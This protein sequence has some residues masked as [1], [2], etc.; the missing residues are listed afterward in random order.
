[1]SMTGGVVF[2]PDL[3]E[4][5]AHSGI[6]VVTTLRHFAIVTYPVE[7]DALK[8]HLHP[9]F[10]PDCVETASGRTVGLV[11]V[12]PFFDVDFCA[13]TFPSPR[14]SFGQTNYR[15]YIH[16]TESGSRAVWF[17]G[18]CLG[19]WTVIVPRY[20]WQLPWHHG[21][22][23]FNCDY[24]VE[25]QRYVRYEMKTDSAWAPASLELEDTGNPVAYFDGFSDLE[26]GLV[27]LTHPLQGFYFRRDGYLGSY[28]IWHD[29][30]Q[31]TEGR[32]VRASFPLL[33]RLGLVRL[34]DQSNPHSVVLQFET[35]FAIY[36]PPKRM[37]HASKL[38]AQGRA[39]QKAA[40]DTGQEAFRRGL[41][42]S[43][44]GPCW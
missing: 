27:V 30:I 11:S 38:H 29:R 37:P 9:R 14:L 32:L 36:L 16:D 10:V 40:P 7:P 19:S 34:E 41:E 17:F 43:R 15:A 2:T 22:I 35:G 20:F 23:R 24:S 5:P 13:A 39:E 42:T 3:L 44:V 25:S 28:R 4:R 33:D 8:Q 31:G 26:S 18:T 1:M 21:R 6:D 12:V